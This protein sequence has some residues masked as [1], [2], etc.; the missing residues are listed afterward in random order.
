M[1]TYDNLPVYKASYD[2]LLETFTL[3]SSFQRQYKYNIWDKIKNE[4]MDLITSIYR[5][6]SSFDTRLQH[7]KKAREQIE[8]LKL[9]LNLI[10]DLKI[11]WLKKHADISLKVEGLSKQMYARQKSVK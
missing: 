9:F 10:H 2:L 11:I 6:N 1:S 3:V 4:I 5:A 8:T 7:L